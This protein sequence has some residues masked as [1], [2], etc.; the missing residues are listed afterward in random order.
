M[1]VYLDMSSYPN[2]NPK[3]RGQNS[4]E[5]NFSD[6]HFHQD[7]GTLARKPSLR[8]LHTSGIHSHGNIYLSFSILLW[9]VHTNASYAPRFL[10]MSAAAAL[11]PKIA[12]MYRITGESP[13]T[14]QTRYKGCNEARLRSMFKASVVQIEVA[15]SAA[16][17]S[18]N[19]NFIPT[20]TVGLG[21]HRSPTPATRLT[22]SYSEVERL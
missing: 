15:G 5:V 19:S 12:G 20:S 21:W 11:P 14:L 22:E 16:R 2:P 3:F 9:L 10:P 17:V 7:F 6:E 8:L 13:E 1:V 18:Q 4:V